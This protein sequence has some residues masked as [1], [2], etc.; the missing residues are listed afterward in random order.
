MSEIYKQ[1]WWDNNLTNNNM[2]NTFL[3]W[4]GDS[5]AESKVFFRN[6]LKDKDYKN[7]VDVG[8]GPATEYFGFKQDNINIEYTGVDS[9]E[10]LFNYNK[11]RDIPMI[12]AEAHRIPVDNDSFEISFSRHV[13]E[14]QPSFKPVLD[15]LI[16]ISSKLAVHIWFHKPEDVEIIDYDDAQK[17]YHNFYKKID[18]EEYLKLNEKIKNFEW[19]DINEKENILLIHMKE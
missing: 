16:R 18:I 11:N 13:L 10:F 12:H 2:F 6:Y 17:L 3:G 5:S 15:E 14:H 1:T 19:V 8:C 4:V 7:I 9:S